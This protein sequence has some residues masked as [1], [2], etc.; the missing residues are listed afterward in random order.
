MRTRWPITLMCEVLEVSGSGYFSWE[1]V[2]RR[3]Q[4]GP[5][6]SHSDEAALAHIR[7]IHEQLGG[8]YGWPRMHK[9]LL[10]RGEKWLRKSEQRD[11]W[12]LWA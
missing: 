12:K 7:A 8:E 2:Q 11:K 3:P 5:R 10:V 4:Q 9:E 1:A 6:R